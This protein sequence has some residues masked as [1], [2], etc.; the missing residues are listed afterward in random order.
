V[1]HGGYGRLVRDLGRF[2]DQLASGLTADLVPRLRA[3]LSSP[4]P[5]E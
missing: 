2:V 3:P 1:R 5:Q 4:N